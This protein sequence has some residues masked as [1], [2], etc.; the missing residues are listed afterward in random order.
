MSDIKENQDKNTDYL[1]LMV[2]TSIILATAITIFIGYSWYKDSKDYE[3][4]VQDS[5]SQ[6]ELDAFL[7]NHPESWYYIHDRFHRN[8]KTLFEDWATTQSVHTCEAYQNFLERHPNC[9]CA[10]KANI[11]IEKLCFPDD[12]VDSSSSIFHIDLNPKCDSLYTIVENGT[13]PFKWL[14]FNTETGTKKL[15]GKLKKAGRYKIPLSKHCR[16]GEEHTFEIRDNDNNIISKTFSATNNGFTL[17]LRAIDNTLTT[18][19]TCGTAP[20]TW[21][22]SDTKSGKSKSSGDIPLAGEH[23]ISLEACCSKSRAYKFEICDASEQCI[24]DTWSNIV[25]SE[26]VVSVAS[27]PLNIKIDP[28]EQKGK[29]VLEIKGGRPPF[30]IQFGKE[31]RPA[32]TLK[33]KRKRRYVFDMKPYRVYPGIYKLEVTDKRGNQ[34]SDTYP[35]GACIKDPLVQLEF[36]PKCW[37]EMKRDSE[38]K[39]IP[40]FTYYENPNSLAS[41]NWNCTLSDE[42]V[43]DYARRHFF[44]N[45]K[46]TQQPDACEDITIKGSTPVIEFFLPDG[47]S[48]EKVYDYHTPYQFLK[49]MER[50]QHLTKQKYLNRI[51][52]AEEFVI[53]IIN[54]PNFDTP[55]AYYLLRTQDGH[56]RWI[57]QIGPKGFVLQIASF[58]EENK[59]YLTARCLQ[60]SGIGKEIYIHPRGED[61]KFKVLVAGFANKKERDDFKDFLPES[62]ICR[63]FLK[64]G[65]RPFAFRVE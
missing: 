28:L 43:A 62:N 39:N 30:K 60:Q 13:P 55:E 8:A 6:E 49:L 32:F 20:Y 12:A 65:E 3:K 61:F 33:G 34:D 52:P 29:L 1:S 53:D 38:S 14:I 41:S 64:K 46:N 18:L 2:A 5:C 40:F 48:I 37:K 21:K 23:N 47:K 44:Y 45:K 63:A 54:P 35:V 58:E 7:A 36:T 31:D 19:I 22:I 59:A 4:L 15:S 11:A 24:S 56:Y 9:A 17:R 42:K 16:E 57:N 51:Q 50:V 10:E 26:M 25:P 27:K